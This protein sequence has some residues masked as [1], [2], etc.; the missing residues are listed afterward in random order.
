MC[1]EY[2]YRV[3]FCIV[4]DLLVLDPRC[5]AFNIV[6]GIIPAERFVLT[7]EVEVVRGL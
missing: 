4:S 2:I 5:E 7:I 3:H 6:F 1:S